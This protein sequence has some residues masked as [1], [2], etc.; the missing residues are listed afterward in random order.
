MPAGPDGLCVCVC[1]FCVT[2]A[3]TGVLKQVRQ[4][5][6]H[7]YHLLCQPCVQCERDE[8]VAMFRE[9]NHTHMGACH[10]EM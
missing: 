7:N 5:I 4:Q 1:C 3:Y 8:R 9:S 10:E 6:Q 2:P